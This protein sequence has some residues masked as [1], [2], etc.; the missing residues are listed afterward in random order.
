VVACRR[1][2]GRAETGGAGRTPGPDFGMSG[3]PL[4]TL[5]PLERSRGWKRSR[6]WKRYRI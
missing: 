4:E 6:S 2:V 3:A 5:A 1:K